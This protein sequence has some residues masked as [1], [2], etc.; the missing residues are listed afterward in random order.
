MV[1]AVIERSFL[2]AEGMVVVVDGGR[3]HQ[4]R[5]AAARAAVRR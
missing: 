2:K 1:R 5:Q 3:A 4:R